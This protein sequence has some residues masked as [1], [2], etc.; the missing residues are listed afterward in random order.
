MTTTTSSIDQT[1][2]RFPW[3]TMERLAYGLLI[4][5]PVIIRLVNLGQRPLAPAEAHTALRAWQASQGMH[6]ALDAGQPLLFTL[7]SLTFF[8]MGATDAL[9]RIWPLLAISALPLSFYFLREWLGR[10]QAL[11]AATLITLSPLANTFARRSDGVSFALL[12]AVIALAGW[13]RV[14]RNQSHGWALTLAGVALALLSGPGGVTIL[15]A[16][17]VLFLLTRDTLPDHPTGPASGD[18]IIFGIILLTGGTAIFTRFDALGLMTI[19]LTQWLTDI[20]LSSRSLLLGFVRLAADEPTLSLFGLLAIVWGLRQERRT[21]ALSIAAG[22]A[23]LIAILQGPDVA[24]S[25]AA[26]AF[27]LALPTAELLVHLARRG[28]FSFRSLEQ[29]LFIAVLILLAFLSVYALVTFAFDGDF[30]RLM[31]FFV[32]ILLGIMIVFLFVW[33]LGWQEVR[34]GLLITSLT[35]TLLFGVSMAWQL[36]FNDTLPTLARVSPTEALPD[37]KDM[38]RTYGDLSEHQTGDRWATEVVLIPGSRSDDMIQWYLR[39]AEDFHIVHS[40][41]A[42]NPPA[43]IIAP[44]EQV[45]TLGDHYAGQRFALLSSWDIG[46]V[47]SLNQGIQWFFFRRAP[48]PPPAADAVNLWAQLVLLNLEQNLNASN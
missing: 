48:F 31:I 33:F 10:W 43:I 9:A 11:L 26:A 4:L 34:G 47:A 7:Q 25:R 36:G 15:I 46:L 6:P 40:V 8:V 35:L 2:C 20:S 24:Y 22:G 3:L 12:A 45:L 32:S 21:R 38:I 39:R 37:V 29:L 30:S 17:A 27:F 28:D 44:A 23:A 16:L 19:N 13:S 41:S 1:A 5:V 18:W 14:V 42:E